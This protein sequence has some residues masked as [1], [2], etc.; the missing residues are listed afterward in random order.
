MPCYVF[1]ITSI[2]AVVLPLWIRASST[3]LGFP[4]TIWTFHFTTA[5]HRLLASLFC[6]GIQ[7]CNAYLWKMPEER[8]AFS[9]TAYCNMSQWFS[10]YDQGP[11]LHFVNQKA[12]ISLNMALFLGLRR[13]SFWMFSITFSMNCP[14]AASTI[15][16]SHH[17]NWQSV[18][19]TLVY[20]F[21][22]LIK[23]LKQ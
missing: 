23:F 7:L 18:R 8:D 1:D 15:N 5:F 9:P 10:D 2:L 11:V 6:R 3:Y 20:M 21:E 12:A 16:N 13:T 4:N 22:V 14:L 17:H 19:R